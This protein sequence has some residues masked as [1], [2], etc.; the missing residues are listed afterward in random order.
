MKHL[1]KSLAE[2]QQEVPVIHK[3]TQGYGYTYADLPK[4]FEVINPLLK[5][6]GLGFT[7]LINGT[8]I[9]TCLFHV[10]SAESIESKIDIPQG[11]ILKGMNE[12]QVLGSAITYLRR[13]ALSSMLG[14]VTDKDTD[15][16]GEQVKHEPKKQAIDNARFQKAIDAISKG[17]YTVEELTTKFSL[18]PAQLKTLEV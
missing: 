1:F 2:F 18:T 7:Q 6:H 9:A 5:K 10:E 13:Y 4:I 8:Q 16:S 14:L 12:F 15:A 11:V 17:E 3:A